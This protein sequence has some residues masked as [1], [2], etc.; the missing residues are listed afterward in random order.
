MAQR[1][2]NCFTCGNEVYFNR[3]VKRKDKP[4]KLQPLA[5]PYDENYDQFP[6]LHECG[7]KKPAYDYQPPRQ[8]QK[9]KPLPTGQQKLNIVNSDD[10]S[11]IKQDITDIKQLLEATVKT[12]DKIL[13]GEGKEGILFTK[14][15]QI[16]QH[17]IDTTGGVSRQQYQED[18]GDDDGE[19]EKRDMD[20]KKDEY[21]Y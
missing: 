20:Y 18:D 14:A 17:E 9:D 21:S 19:D 16:A 8:E 7:N 10:I 13:V 12:L 5:Q 2:Y 11:K 6:V 3:N 15:S 4:D 1:T